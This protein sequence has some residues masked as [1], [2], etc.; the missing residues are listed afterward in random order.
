MQRVSAPVWEEARDSHSREEVYHF[1]Y[2]QYFSS[3]EY[4]PGIDHE[5]QRVWLPHDDSSRHFLARTDD[6]D[7]V[8][9]ATATPAGDPGLFPEWQEIFDLPRLWEL[10]SKITVIS[11]AIVAEQARSSAIFGKMCL[12]LASLFLE[13]GYHYALHYCAPGMVS[14]YERLGYRQYGRGRNLQS[15][16]YRIPMF[17]VADDTDYMRRLRSP[18]RTLQ[19]DFEENRGWI[20]KAFAICPELTI[21]PLCM[22]SEKALAEK[23]QSLCPVLENKLTPSLVHALR[24]GSLLTLRRGDILAPAGIN[25]GCFLLLTGSLVCGGGQQIPGS[26]FSTGCGTVRAREDVQLICAPLK[27]GSCNVGC[28]C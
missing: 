13:E 24:R 6:G 19:R 2:V 3:R 14:M 20:E 17:L 11:R 27:E 9:V 15:G 7:V 26:I 4:L 28:P 16:V 12:R 22:L 1:R 21:S 25:E 23:I 18:F 5:R 10:V 8:A